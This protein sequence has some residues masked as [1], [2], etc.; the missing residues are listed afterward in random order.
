MPTSLTQELFLAL[1]AVVNLVLSW[2]DLFWL[3][4]ALLIGLLVHVVLFRT[5]RTIARKTDTIIDDLLV[6]HCRRPTRMIITLI[7]VHLAMPLI[8]LSQGTAISIRQLLGIL[9]IAS[10]SW[11][12]IQMSHGLEEYIMHQFRIDTADNLR[13]RRI[14][15]Q[16]RIL[17]K[18]IIVIV[19]T[20]GT[21]A[22]LMNFEKVRQLGTSIL[23]SAGIAG[24]ILG[25]AAQRSIGTLIAVV[26]IAIT[27]PILLDDVVIVEDEWG[28]IEEITLTYV[29]VRIWD[30]RRLILPI[31]YFIEKPFQNWTRVT[32][33]ILGTVFIYTDYTI[34]VESIRSELE[35][36][37]RDSPLWDSKVWNLQVTNTTEKGIELRALMSA[38]NAS[39]AWTLRCEVREKLLQFIQKN[40]PKNLPKFR[41]EISEPIRSDPTRS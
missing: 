19:G 25:L 26:Q 7:A 1:S 34:P 38:S 14:H 4:A 15:T 28:R 41:A 29:V 22:I 24:I 27:Q 10:I 2:K 3:L 20:L 40:Y 31:T 35:R 5:I 16:L 23:A 13:A 30:L 12:L 8:H 18:V 32:S 36:I 33:D 37:L 39:R 6:K 21:A 9:L 11:L 17:K